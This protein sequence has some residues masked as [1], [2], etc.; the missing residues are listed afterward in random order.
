M[1]ALLLM[2]MPVGA[3]FDENGID[4]NTYR[5]SWDLLSED[6]NDGCAWTIR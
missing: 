4:Y 6:E 5:N 3:I 2:I 1:I